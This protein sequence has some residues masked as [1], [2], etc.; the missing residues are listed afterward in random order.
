MCFSPSDSQ[1]TLIFASN[2]HT[3]G[4]RGT[5]YKRSNETVGKDGEKSETNEL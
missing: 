4:H 2:F 1:G 3:L 5:L